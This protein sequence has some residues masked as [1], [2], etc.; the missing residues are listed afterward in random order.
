MY[1]MVCTRPDL[2]YA[3]STISRFMSNSGKQHWEPGKWVLRYLRGTARLSLVFQ[4]LKTGKPRELQGYVD[5]DYARDLYQ[6][7]SMTG[8]VFIVAEC[9]ISWKAELQ[10]T[11][12]LSTTEAE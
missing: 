8:Y 10:D 11:V 3:V 5:I 9:A 2:A 6:R 7:R 1:A 4:R 12:A